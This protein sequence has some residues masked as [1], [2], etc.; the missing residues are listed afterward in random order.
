DRETLRFLAVNDAAVRHYGYSRDEFATMTLTD[1]RPSEDAPALLDHLGRASG[2]SDARLWR[3]RKRDGALITVAIRGSDF[4]ME[5]RNVRLV[6]VHDVTDREEAR[7]A[8]RKTEDQLRH[9]QKTDAIGQLAGGVAHDFNNLLT[10]IESYACI[11]L[12]ALEATDPRHE[13]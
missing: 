6:L 13:D 1:I 11:L 10:V 8:L 9:A 7:E 4:V 12:D 5:G 2:P 3:H